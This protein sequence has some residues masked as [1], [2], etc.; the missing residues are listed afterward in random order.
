MSDLDRRLSRLEGAA[1]AGAERLE[2]I[3]L[4]GDEPE[5][6]AAEPPQPGVMRLR[7]RFVSPMPDGA[8]GRA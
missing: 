8:H 4:H 2:V 6:E 3:F 1:G 5:P 7:V